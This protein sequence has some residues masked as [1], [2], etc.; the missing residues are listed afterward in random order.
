MKKRIT[1]TFVFF[2]AT[3]IFAY[4]QPKASQFSVFGGVHFYDYKTYPLKFTYD[5]GFEYRYYPI[6]RLFFVGQGIFAKGNKMI[7]QPGEYLNANAHKSYVWVGR[8][9]TVQFGAGIGGDIVNI[10]DRHKIYIQAIAG[11]GRY[12]TFKQYHYSG[13]I[14][15][16]L[17]TRDVD[18]FGEYVAT[19]LGYDFYFNSIVSLGVF[20]G[21][22]VANGQSLY[23]NGNANLKL[24][25]L[26]K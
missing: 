8:A 3:T 20:G 16:T 5:F 14:R 13:D 7:M 11:F 25:V 1:I 18:E 4:S 15:G 24:S 26:L 12:Y 22:F 2:V 9:R 17:E 10:K 6:N 19:Q 21:I 23:L